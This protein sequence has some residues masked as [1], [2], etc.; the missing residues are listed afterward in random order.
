MA[1]VKN[2]GNREEMQQAIAALA[3]RRMAEDG[4]DLGPARHKAAAEIMGGAARGGGALPDHEQVE[5]ALRAY[6]EQHEGEEHRQRLRRL[7]MLALAWMEELAPFQPHLV[8][9]VLN[10]SATEHAHLHLHLFADSAKD[11]EMALLDRGLDIRVGPAEDAP[12][13]AQMRTHVQEVIGFMAPP[14]RAAASC[15]GRGAA[16]ATPILLTILDTTALRQAPARRSDPGLHAV[17]R[18]GRASLPMLRELIDASPDP[19]APEPFHA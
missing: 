18:A 15:A 11:V 13:S 7:R 4:L 19:A 1:A 17:E 3:A 9:A 2:G 5:S 6:L 14:A 16:A 8:G 10:G 12:A